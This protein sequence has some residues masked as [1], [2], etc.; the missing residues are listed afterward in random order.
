[1]ARWGDP[2]SGDGEFFINL[3]DSTN[4]D[5]SGDDGWKLGFTVFGQVCY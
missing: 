5:R 3:K 2:G 4:L 1:M